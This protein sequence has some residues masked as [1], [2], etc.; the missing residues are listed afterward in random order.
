MVTE[1]ATYNVLLQNTDR[2]ARLPWPNRCFWSHPPQ[3]WKYACNVNSF[4]SAKKN[5]SRWTA[6]CAARAA[7]AVGSRQSASRAAL[8]STPSAPH[9]NLDA[10]LGSGRAPPVSLPPEVLSLLSQRQRNVLN[11]SPT[12]LD[13]LKCIGS[14]HY[15]KSS[16][17]QFF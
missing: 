6:A 11:R 14:Y 3:L 2:S 5:R 7:A 16:K 9:L 8:G 15:F 12:L 1:A 4:A 10:P 17:E 13:M